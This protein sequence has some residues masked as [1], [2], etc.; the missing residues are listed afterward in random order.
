MCVRGAACVL[1]CVHVGVW[2]CGWGL[3]VEVGGRGL[4]RGG[5]GVRHQRMRQAE[6]QFVPT[7]IELI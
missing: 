5:C 7:A 2:V 6:P 3:G 4:S 1:D